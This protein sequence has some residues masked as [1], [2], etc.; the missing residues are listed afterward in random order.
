M[1]AFSRCLPFHFEVAFLNA[2]DL[3]VLAEPKPLP[4]IAVLA[5]V[6][7]RN[8]PLDD[9]RRLCGLAG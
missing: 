7:K 2:P 9:F 3:R 4:R 8:F 6:A 5:R 1:T